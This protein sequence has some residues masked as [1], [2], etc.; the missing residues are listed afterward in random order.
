MQK[1]VSPLLTLYLYVAKGVNF[2]RL[3]TELLMTC[4]KME[5][6]IGQKISAFEN[7][8]NSLSNLFSP[9]ENKNS[10]SDTP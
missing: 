3:G 8:Q 2:W 7:G 1:K 9:F 5:A 6:D 10:D 4:H